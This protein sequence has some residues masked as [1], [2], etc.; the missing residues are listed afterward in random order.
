MTLERQL[1]ERPTDD[2]PAGRVTRGGLLEG[3]GLHAVGGLHRSPFTI[4]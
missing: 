4:G 1:V 3:I 2:A